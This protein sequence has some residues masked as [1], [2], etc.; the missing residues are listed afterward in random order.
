[1]KFLRLTI[2]VMLVVTLSACGGSGGL[3]N[4]LGGNPRGNQCNTGTSEQPP[5]GPNTNAT[6]TRPTPHARARKPPLDTNRLRSALTLP[7]T[8]PVY[9][10]GDT[11]VDDYLREVR[12]L[13]DRPRT[14]QRTVYRPGEVCQFDLWQP[15]VE[16]PVG[17]GQTR[18][19]WVVVAC[20]GYSR[21][22]AGALAGWLAGLAL[23]AALRLARRGV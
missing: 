12:P 21:A 11:V 1:M 4:I 14:F 19:A 3:G 20:L 13:F 15:S 22:G 7:T 23:H 10:S 16:V 18:R 5:P 6:T 17:H 8:P 2:P 9:V